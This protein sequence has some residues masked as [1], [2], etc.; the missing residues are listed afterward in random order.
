MLLAQGSTITLPEPGRRWW[1][2]TE[3]ESLVVRG[4]VV[5]VSTGGRPAAQVGAFAAEERAWELARRLQLLGFP[6]EVVPG[7]LA[8]VVALGA[9]GEGH[10][11]LGARLG[12]AGFGEHLARGARGAELALRGE[13]GVRVVGQWARLRPMDEAPADAGGVRVRGDVVL[14]PAAD[15]A[16]LINELNL[17]DYLRG[18]VP[19][20][21]GPRAF[22][23]LE[24]LK[25]QAVA[26]RTYAVAHLGEHDEE[27]YDL[28]ATTQCQV[29]KGAAA[30][31]PLSDR[32]VTETAGEVLV[33]QGRLVDARY[34]STCGGHTEDAAVSFPGLEAP[35]LRGVAC[36]H[37]AWLE[38]GEGRPVGPWLGDAA[39][40][41][42]VAT[43]LAARLG[44]VPRASSLATALGVAGWGGGGV[45]EAS[46]AELAPLLHV[47]EGSATTAELLRSAR[48]APPG[49]SGTRE[50]RR[51]AEVVRVAQALGL[52]QELRGTVV[53]NG[54]AVRFLA[55][56]GGA[57]VNLVGDELVLERRG[58]EARQA[59]VRTG[60]G[61]PAA[62]WM[63]RGRCEAVELEAREE[64]DAA[65]A[66]S[67]WTRTLTWAEIGSRL[68]FD[69]VRSVVVLARG[70]S[71]RAA[72]VR[73]E[74]AGGA[75]E[76][77]GA[78][79]RLALGLPDTLFSV[80]RD[81]A[82]ALFTGRGWGHGVGM[83]Q[84]GAYGLALGGA[85][86]EQI[87]KTYYTGVELRRP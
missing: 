53:P 44:V 20:E 31:D 7:Q 19:A 49:P 75:R 83:C 37:T 86:Y 54:A 79:L 28:C 25:A 70:V 64:A 69:G 43:R 1:C 26:A 61:S 85:T 67:W 6:A 29:Y 68:G 63:F 21:M 78:Q 58:T 4:P 82:S 12:A 18:V 30:E 8:A 65:S 9:P 32:A 59:G 50:E 84:N 76:M 10:Q 52:V 24:A 33:W 71:G 39:R 40:L 55:S 2:T 14:R 13:G 36:R 66:W 5:A 27:G 60:P 77:S 42:A 3:R 35:Y 51:L 17:E 23:A 47:P 34:H 81:G 45:G 38:I 41:A 80:R 48:V 62:A 56:S 16:L 22:P 74:T 57:V 15:G 73:V 46:A 87:L 72:R 11:A